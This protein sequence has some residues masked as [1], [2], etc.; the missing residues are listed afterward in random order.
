VQAG[1]GV[2]AG[3]RTWCCGPPAAILICIAALS[4][5]EPAL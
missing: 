4:G 2:R 1:D 5:A 3:F